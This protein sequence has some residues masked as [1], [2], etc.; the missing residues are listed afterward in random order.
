LLAVGLL[1]FDWLLALPGALLLIF[2]ML[3]AILFQR[4]INIAKSSVSLEVDPKE[5]D[6]AVGT[7]TKLR[8]RIRNA[9]YK[10]F[11]FVDVALVLPPGVDAR[12]RDS[13]T[14]LSSQTEHA[15]ELIINPRSPGRFEIPGT[16]LT[17]EDAVGMFRQSIH[18]RDRIVVTS[19]PTPQGTKTLSNLG[20]LFDLAADPIRRGIGTDL[21][22]FRPF[23]FL[24][25]FHRIDWKATARMGRVIARDYQAD[26]EPTIMLVIDA[27]ALAKS[28]SSA[29]QAS[30]LLSQ[31][32]NLINDPRLNMSAMGLI[33]YDE[34]RIV[35]RC[36]PLQGFQNRTKLLR[37]LARISGEGSHPHQSM[38]QMS[39]SYMELIRE[40][41]L[42]TAK[43]E[44]SGTQIV[45]VFT[46][47]A[48]KLLP[49][50][51]AAA[52]SHFQML[53]NHGV[54]QAF[55]YVASLRDPALI[56]SISN[57]KSG[58]QAL[59]EGVKM[60]AS[61][62]HKIIVAL[63]QMAHTEVQDQLQELN[64]LGSGVALTS[65]KE[66]WSAVNRQ[67]LLIRPQR[68]T[69]TSQVR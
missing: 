3:Q 20:V 1:L 47:F 26:R 58:A 14:T 13:L 33:L 63:I 37:S 34:N 39:C 43:L 61:M 7:S 28:P 48:N 6:L 31:L 15:L 36:E 19:F 29:N 60:A 10:T 67:L 52:S 5:V 66:L 65:T 40:T 22:G 54:F 68:T 38:G 50:Y 49:Y 9:S 53:R 45:E 16:I 2:L 44:Q 69:V 42:L 18:F 23:T 24:D 8:I 46:S 27:S 51:R 59:I 25:D 12:S 56:L 55:E 30:N 35:T 57:V 41:R 4:A 17:L 62:N 32:G 11:R 21:A 64:D